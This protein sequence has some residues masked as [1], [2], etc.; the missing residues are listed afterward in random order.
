MSSSFGDRSLHP[1]YN[2]ANASFSQFVLKLAGRCDLACDYCYVYTMADRRWRDRPA[3]MSAAIA[4]RTAERI[5]EHARA[6]R[7]DAVS[8]VL[9]GGEPLLAGAGPIGEVAAAVRDALPAGCRAV[10]D[11][12]TNGVLLDDAVLTVL[13]KHG[14]G[15]SVSLDGDARAHDRHRRRRDGHGSHEW[16]QQALQ[17]LAR[18]EYRPLFSGLLC[19]VDLRNDPI[20][21]Y[22]ALLT[23]APPQI[24]FL[25]P[26]GNWTAPPP[27]RGPDP[28]ATPYADWLIPIFDAWYAGDGATGV[29]LFDDIMQTLLGGRSRVDGVG[30]GPAGYL[31]VNTDGTVECGDTVNAS[32]EG[33]AD[34]GLDVV[35]HAFD[36]VL[37]VPA[38]RARLA[39]LHRLGAQCRA[40]ALLSVCGGGLPAHRYRAGHGFA[41]PSVYCPDLFAL[42]SHIRRAVARDVERMPRLSA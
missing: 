35:R 12:Q 42:I 27:G 34:T 14:I 22:R 25:L 8:V 16:V 10:V 1:E 6:H 32:L 17:R 19:T 41:N 24:D 40:C 9:H 5:G 23:H 21:T 36:E 3:L 11:I 28:G 15:V 29:R 7:L 26:H 4:D 13:A 33:A 2:F 31:V 37:T 30:R 39:G 18:P 38:V 20:G